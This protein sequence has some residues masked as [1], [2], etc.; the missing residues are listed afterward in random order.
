VLAEGPRPALELLS[1]AEDFA[2]GRGLREMVMALSN[3]RVTALF[4]IGAWDEMLRIAG[5]VTAEAR[6][7]GS[8]Y[9]EV[10]AEADRAFV[11][12]CRRDPSAHELCE[13]VLEQARSVN[14]PP[15]L[16]RA[17]GAAALARSASG[18]RPGSLALVQE[19][20]DITAGEAAVRLTELP[21]LVR[22]AVEG[23]DLSLAERL[24]AGTETGGLEWYRLLR[25]T[26][27]AAID[28]ARGEWERA[29]EGYDEASTGWTEWGHELE[30]AHS[31]SGSARCL[32]AL[33]RDDEAA[34]RLRAAVEAFEGLGMQFGIR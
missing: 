16:L 4:K 14:E 11:L 2:E 21:H 18:D 17:L 20:L 6:R 31:L 33:G 12:A 30:R 26:A 25:L 24:M 23:A 5:E 28:E 29:L 19:A 3:Q 22:L 9:D 13:S 10:F 32:A 7:Q 15:I 1:E 27:R 34:G 8:S